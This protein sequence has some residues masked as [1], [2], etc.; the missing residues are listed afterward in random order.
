MDI[1]TDVEIAMPSQQR[2]GTIVISRTE[3]VGEE[4]ADGVAHNACMENAAA[5]LASVPP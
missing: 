3:F 1:I 2:Q 4:G 5:P